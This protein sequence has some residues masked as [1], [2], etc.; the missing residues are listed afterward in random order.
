MDLCWPVQLSPTVKSVLISLADNA[1]DD[2]ICWPSIATICRR[3]CLSDKSVRR[4]IAELEVQGLLIRNG[5]V[6][7]VSKY[8][9]V[10][11]NPGHCGQTGQTDTPVTQ[12]ITP[13]TVTSHPGH[14]V[15]NPGHCDQQNHKNRKE[16]SGTV[17]DGCTTGGYGQITIQQLQALGVNKQVAS[18]FIALRK[19]KK[20]NL[21]PLALEG[22]RREAGIAGLSLNDALRTCI[23]KGWQGFSADW[24]SNRQR[25][26]P[27]RD[28]DRKRALD[29]L[30][31]RSSNDHRTIDITATAIRTN[32]MD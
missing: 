12:S 22:I 29:E 1:N 17:N 3:T 9:I 4:A 14:T 27:S 30:T 10:P 21:T 16:P 5:Q 11:P 25:A 13:V 8:K 15:H 24:L 32:P 2:G 23:E 28:E 20:S 19:R 18:E 7:T 26:G 6:G 31:G